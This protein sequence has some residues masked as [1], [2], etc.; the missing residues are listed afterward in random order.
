MLKIV[1]LKQF[2]QLFIIL[3][4][5]Y[6]LQWNDQKS[7]KNAQNSAFQAIS[8]VFHNFKRTIFSSWNVQQSTINAENSKF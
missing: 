3:K 8:A 6:F 2:K 4:E 1:H 7:A 5:L